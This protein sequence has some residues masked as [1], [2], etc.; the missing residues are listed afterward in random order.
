EGNFWSLYDNLRPRYSI[1]GYYILP[2]KN[3][4]FLIIDIMEN[5]TNQ[6]FH[7]SGVKEMLESIKNEN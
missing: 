1:S 3:G 4:D 7:E 2:L 6:R 5:Q